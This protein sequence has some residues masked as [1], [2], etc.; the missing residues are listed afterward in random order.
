MHLVWLNAPGYLLVCCYKALLALSQYFK[1][2]LGVALRTALQDCRQS[3]RR[4]QHS[5]HG[6]QVVQAG[7]N[8]CMHPRH[9]TFMQQRW[10][11]VS[12]EASNTCLLRVRVAPELLGGTCPMFP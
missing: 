11:S 3:W 1:C 5:C 12:T 9:L 8:V 4:R 2:L 7:A 10:W 6:C